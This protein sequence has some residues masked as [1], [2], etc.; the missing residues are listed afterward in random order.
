MARRRAAEKFSMVPLRVDEAIDR[1]ELTARRGELL[2]RLIYRCGKKGETQF[3]LAEL[4]EWL[5]GY[6]L[7]DEA[8]R[9]DLVALE[10]A[11]WV[12]LWRSRGH[13]KSTWRLTLGGA[14]VEFISSDSKSPEEETQPE[15]GASGTQVFLPPKSAATTDTDTDVDNFT[16]EAAIELS[17]RAVSADDPLASLVSRLKDRDDRTLA[18]FRKQF[19]Y[20]SQD[21]AV[22]ALERLE[23]RRSQTAKGRRAALRS[24]ASYVHDF[25]A[26]RVAA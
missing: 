12:K 14:A 20:V 22:R 21:V 16:A 18:V 25:L 5:R 15:D 17:L 26:K 4:R 8:L 23:W 24:E 11:G 10:K 2:K 9:R 1:E 3:T 6:T 13:G 7:A 19:A